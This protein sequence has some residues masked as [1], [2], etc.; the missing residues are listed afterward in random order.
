[1][2]KGFISK[3]KLIF[4]PCQENKYRPRFLD[5]RFL[6]YYLVFL[7]VL[8][9]IIAPIFICFPK[10][11]FFASLVKSSVIEMTNMERGASAV[12][13]LY[14]NPKLD[15]AAYLKAKD[16]MEKDYFSHESPEGVSPWHWF[17]EAGYDYKFAGENL[18]I[19]F[20]DSEEVVQAWMDSPSHRANLLNPNYKE[21]GIA[22]LTGDFQGKETTI[23]VQLFG[24]LQ[25]FSSA[26]EE[27]IPEVAIK[28]EKV[29]NTGIFV[30]GEGLISGQQDVISTEF[31]RFLTSDY[32]NL[33]QEIAYGSL[34]LIL[35]SLL[36]TVF[37]DLFV[38]IKLQIQ[39]KDLVFKTIGLSLILVLFILIDKEKI[40]QL[41][42]HNF[43]IY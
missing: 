43:G 28:E 34:I 10:S 23:V 3:L 13:S 4:I 38:Y 16:M 8:K 12:S 14:E 39:Y 7:F 42:P 25:S 22:V 21:I 20:L 19:G 29:Q 35:I 24:T 31:V 15:T 6:S 32:Y 41:I 1:M 37:F 26:E 17:K 5:S 33:I 30:L 11:A 2:F 40:I 36:V 18:A 9:I 27:N